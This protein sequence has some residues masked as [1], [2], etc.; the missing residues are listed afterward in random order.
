[1]SRL[2]STER[3]ARASARRPWLTL[4]LWAVLIACAVIA[5][6]LYSG[7]LSSEDSFVNNPESKK[8]QELI[9][10]R[11]PSAGTEPEVIVIRSSSSTI[12]DPH[13]KTAVQDLRSAIAEIGPRDIAWVM[14]YYDV[15]GTGALEEAGAF[16]SDD[17]RTTII[18]VT[19]NSA[20]GEIMEHVEPLYAL[21]QETRVRLAAEGFTVA[22]IDNATWEQELQAVADSDLTRGE[23]IGVP[24]AMVV[25]LIV[26]GALVAAGVPF[27]LALAGITLALAVVSLLAQTFTL[28][29]FAAN[30]VTMMGLA[31]GIDYALFILSRFREERAAGFSVVDA[32][33]RSGA[34]ASRAVLFSGITVILALTGML[35]IPFSIFTSMGLGMILVVFFAVSAA[36]TLLPAL[37]ALLGDRVNSLRVPFRRPQVGTAGEEGRWGGAVRALMQHP[38]VTLV[39]GAGLLIALTVPGFGLERGESGVGHLPAHLSARQA[40]EILVEDFSPGL[41]SPLLITLDGEQQ[42]P[43]AQ[44]AIGR[45]TDAAVADGRFEV[46]GYETSADGDFGLLKLALAGSVS[47]SSAENRAVID[48]RTTI[49][50]EAIGDAPLAALVGGAPAQFADMLVIVDRMTPVVFAV[51]LSLCFILLLVAFRS[52]V[53]ATIAVLMNLLSVGAAYGL[54][55]LV[56]QQG[57]GAGLFGFQQTPQ[58]TTWVPLLLF[59]ILFGLSM[60]YQVFLISRIREHYDRTG[61]TREAVVFGVSSTAGIITGAALIMVAVFGGMASGELVMF[62]QIGFGLA[63]AIALDAT[64]VRT[65]VMPALMTLLGRWNWYLPYWLSWLPQVCVET[66]SLDTG[67][68]P[69]IEA[70]GA[71]APVA[72]E[73]A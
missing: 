39:V 60:D 31:V 62:Q 30:V 36:L 37:L 21:V 19:L 44:A 28:S 70:P 1:M 8:A 40:Y 42:D 57:V 50:P 16:V 54:L 6:V 45:L 47:D 65:L 27:I 71:P 4:G 48:L 63:V 22:M 68:P 61:D 55:V 11:L 7:S 56:F 59:C 12:D 38:V 35:I 34:T 17:R 3:M 66:S 5:V 73:Q 43:E 52:L 25:L 14:T 2:S 20:D 41:T 26:F 32:V 18:P 10:E 33:G 51:V 29:V 67:E 46:V 72:T 64:V 69:S 15:A 24:I 9:E 13:M 58:I 53:I 49:I 23:V